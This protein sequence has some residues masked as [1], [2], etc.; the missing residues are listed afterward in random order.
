MNWTPK[1][2]W[3]RWHST[4]RIC[5]DIPLEPSLIVIA[6]LRSPNRSSIPVRF[7]PQ[8]PPY[9]KILTYVS[10]VTCPSQYHMW[11]SSITPSCRKGRWCWCSISE[12]FRHAALSD[13][14]LSTKA[15]GAPELWD[16]SHSIRVQHDSFLRWLVKSHTVRFITIP[17]TRFLVDAMRV[18]QLHQIS[19]H[20]MGLYIDC[21]RIY[22]SI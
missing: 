1:K 16:Y 22:S 12:A 6:S 10:Y 20:Y 15:K 21:C 4:I 17:N 19:A 2:W 8:I 9:M 18:P 11:P 13:E 5:G 3:P 7:C 14:C